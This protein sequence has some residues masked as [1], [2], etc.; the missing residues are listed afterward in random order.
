MGIFKTK[1]SMAEEAIFLFKC[2]PRSQIIHGRGALLFLQE[3]EWNGTLFP[4]SRLVHSY[5][6]QGGKAGDGDFP[7]MHVTITVPLG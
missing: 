1:L 5:G 6:T 2:M 3:E 7:V 4:Q